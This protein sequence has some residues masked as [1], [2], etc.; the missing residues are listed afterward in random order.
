[1]TEEGNFN[2]P[3]KP[4]QRKKKKKKNDII[5]KVVLP[6]I[7]AS[8]PVIGVIIV[9]L[10]H[11]KDIL[12][13]CCPPTAMSN[14]GTPTPGLTPISS[15][16]TLVQ[17]NFVADANSTTAVTLN[18]PVRKGDLILVAITQFERQ[19]TNITDSQGDTYTKVGGTLANPVEGQDFVELY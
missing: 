4:I 2:A 8:I 19:V 7:L 5:L 14:V 9:A 13:P 3:E 18:Q 17:S 15:P 6:I 1:L 12:P 11:E 10:I 16:P